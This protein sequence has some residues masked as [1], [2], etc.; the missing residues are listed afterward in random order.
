[1]PAAGTRTSSS[2]IVG[3]GVEP[4]AAAAVALVVAAGRGRRRGCGPGRGPGGAGDGPRLPRRGRSGPAGSRLS[5]WSSRLPVVPLPVA[6]LAVTVAA[7]RRAGPRPVAAVAV[8]DWLCRGSGRR[9]S[10]RWFSPVAV[11]VAGSPRSPRSRRRGRR[12]LLG[13]ASSAA[14]AR[15]RRRRSRAGAAGV[16]AAVR[17]LGGGAV[18][19]GAFSAA[20]RVR[21]LPPS[22]LAGPV[23]LGRGA[24]RRTLVQGRLARLRAGAARGADPPGRP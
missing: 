13:S 14:A 23:G 20:A 5:R 7:D 21:R 6:V 10:G 2:L 4:L 17:L 1:M 15:P 16:A 3:S 12:G 8:A 18:L 9:G 24:P 19:A 22:R 11:A